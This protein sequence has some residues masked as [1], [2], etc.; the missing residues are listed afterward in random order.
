MGIV[1][2]YLID[3]VSLQWLEFLDDTYEVLIN[4]GKKGEAKLLV[5]K[6]KYSHIKVDLFGALLL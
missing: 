2:E 3:L 6:E 1:L 4:K 5:K